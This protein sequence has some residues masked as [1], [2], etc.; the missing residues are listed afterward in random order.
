MGVASCRVRLCGRVGGV[1]WYGGCSP[2]GA[3]LAVGDE[4][5]EDVEG[6][7]AY[8]E[9]EV[10]GVVRDVVGGDRRRR[11]VRLTLSTNPAPTPIY[12]ALP[13]GALAITLRN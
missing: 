1:A 4:L 5:I 2:L 11:R 13:Q 7:L 10:C 8:N 12:P 6:A 9:N 3:Q